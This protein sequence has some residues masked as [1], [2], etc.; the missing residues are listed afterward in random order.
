MGAWSSE[1]EPS[2]G[3]A[4]RLRLPDDDDGDDGDDNGSASLAPAPG[5][6][7]GEMTIAA[8]RAAPEDTRAIL[9]GAVTL[10]PG[11][12]GRN[13]YIQDA[14]GGMRVYLRKGDYPSLATGDL[15]RVTGW[16]RS[17]HGETE[18]SSP[19][20][21]YLSKVSAGVRTAPTRVRTGKVGEAEEGRLALL[22]GRA[23]KYEWDAIVLDDGTGPVR[24]F[25]PE[26]LPWRRPYVR[27]GDWWAAQGVIGQYAAQ[28]P[29][30]GGYR[31]IPVTRPD[32]ALPPV[33]LPVTGG[34]LPSP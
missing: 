9:V 20:A 13:M 19:D 34:A 26:D 25:F 15:V 4:N 30:L 6:F 23:V 31:L 12:F 29:F 7:G 3:W 21:G 17:Y 28:A 2:P 10:P 14:T 16:T 22:I 24:V 8:A 32:L 11:M 18:L 33:F 1:C 5:V 27:I